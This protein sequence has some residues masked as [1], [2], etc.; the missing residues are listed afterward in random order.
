MDVRK[1]QSTRTAKFDART[2]ARKCSRKCTQE[3]T[4]RCP[5]KCPRRLRLFLWNTYQRVP[6]KTPTRVL[7]G[8]FSSAHE[9]VHAFGQGPGPLTV[10]CACEQ[11]P[12][13]ASPYHDNCHD[14]R[15]GQT[16]P[17]PKQQQHLSHT[18]GQ[19]GTPHT[20]PSPGI[21]WSWL[22]V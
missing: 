13:S 19:S 9:N 8:K 10:M 4:R 7:H 16:L 18:P 5:R 14:K 22:E 21:A 6:T 20:P 1:A 17:H 12:G 3:C 2:L 11:D 15:Q